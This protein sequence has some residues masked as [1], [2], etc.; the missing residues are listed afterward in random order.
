M[1]IEITPQIF[2][3]TSEIAESFVRSSGPGGQN[4]NKLETAVQLRFNVKTSGL[5]EYVKLKLVQVAGQRMNK[6][7]EILIVAQ[8]HRHREQNR[9]A[10]LERLILLIKDAAKKPRKRR[11]TRVPNAAR[12]KRLEAKKRRSE[13]KKNRGR[14]DR[15]SD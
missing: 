13:T 14:A 12:R 9:A 1:Q 15:F 3:D 7:G 5:P 6:N 8:E 11:R 4:V 2:I 10:A